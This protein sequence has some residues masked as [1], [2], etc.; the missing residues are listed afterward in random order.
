M[1]SFPNGLQ[2]LID[3]L[4]ARLVTPVRC[5]ANVQALIPDQTRW[6]VRLTDTELLADA[7]VLACPADAQADLLAPLDASLAA[8]VRAIEYNRVAV[9]AL[10]YRRVDVP[11]PLDGFGYLTPQRERLD[12]LGAQ[13]CSSIFPDHRAPHEH[14][15]IRVLAGGWNRPDLLDRDDSALIA[16]ACTQ[17]QTALGISAQPIFQEVVRWYRAI[18]QYFL[19]HLDR[20]QRIESRLNAHPGLFLTGNAYRGVAINDCVE[21]SRLLADEITGKLALGESPAT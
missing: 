2:E 15:L 3:A 13:W 5:Q 14:V 10:G 8:E 17:L 19:G 21:R 6:R 20:L 9:I 4:V 16:A 18:P 7:V 11:H 1:W 12:A